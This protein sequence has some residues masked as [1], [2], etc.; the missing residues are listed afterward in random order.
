MP[1][2]EKHPT[3]KEKENNLLQYIHKLIV[4]FEIETGVYVQSYTYTKNQQRESTELN[5]CL[6]LPTGVR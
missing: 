1:L 6:L 5:T 2:N 3:L 4:A